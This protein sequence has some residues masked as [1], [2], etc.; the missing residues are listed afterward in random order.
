MNRAARIHQRRV[1]RFVL[2]DEMS[3]YITNL[4]LA[5]AFPHDRFPSKKLGVFSTLNNET[6]IRIRRTRDGQSS[7][8]R[9]VPWS[10]FQQKDARP[11]R[12]TFAFYS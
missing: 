12:G 9:I 1:F 3:D 7:D 6:K 5:L 2:R 11:L 10:A 8:S 4:V